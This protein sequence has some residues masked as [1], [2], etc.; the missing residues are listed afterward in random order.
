MMTPTH[1]LV[2]GFAVHRLRRTGTPVPLGPALL[3]AVLPDFPLA[4]LT[5]WY[6]AV[7]RAANP[8]T[9]NDVFGELYD[10]YFFHEPA[11]IA[12]HNALHA[13]LILAGLFAAGWALA[14]WGRTGG[15]ALCWFAISAAVHTA[16]D[17]VS[18][19]T[20]G[21]LL[22]FPVDWSF[23]LQAPVSYWDPRY[24]GAIFVRLEI[25]LDVLL[26]LYF[27]AAFLERRRV[28]GEPRSERPGGPRVGAAS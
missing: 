11:W 28:R 14:R 22:L 2:T 16:L 21:P 23:R 12:A 8:A 27:L 26:A 10:R 5:L 25:A 24:G 1:F 20:D 15:M 18:H 7:P 6:L 13:P 4:L 19:H 3:G 9:G 17:T